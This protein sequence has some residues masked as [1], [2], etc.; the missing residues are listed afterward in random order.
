MESGEERED[1][2]RSNRNGRIRRGKEKE[3]W[4]NMGLNQR[5]GEQEMWVG[6]WRSGVTW[7]VMVGAEGTRVGI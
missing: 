4:Q 5:K 6:S 7:S 1:L 3:L 2:R